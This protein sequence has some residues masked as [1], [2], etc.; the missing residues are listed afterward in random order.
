MSRLNPMDWLTILASLLSAASVAGV[1][2]GVM[3]A[4]LQSLRRELELLRQRHDADIRE[5]RE[6]LDRRINGAHSS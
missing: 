2:V 1:M 5:L 6:R 3:R 4:S